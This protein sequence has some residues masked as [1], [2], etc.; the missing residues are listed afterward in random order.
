MINKRYCPLCKRHYYNGFGAH[1]LT[2]DHRMKVKWQ[3]AERKAEEAKL[4]KENEFNCQLASALEGW[5]LN[6]GDVVQLRDGR[7]FKVDIHGT[8]FE[9]PIGS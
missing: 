2:Y 9:I 8:L 1:M 3:I 6:P 4:Q 5:T 7:T